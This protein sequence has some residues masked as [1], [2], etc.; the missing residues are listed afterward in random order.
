M[1]RFLSFPFGFDNLCGY[2]F[3]LS[4]LS[5]LSKVGFLDGFLSSSGSLF[6]IGLMQF[7]IVGVVSSH[8][9]FS[10]RDFNF[11]FLDNEGRTFSFVFTFGLSLLISLTNLCLE[12]FIL[13]VCKNSMHPVAPQLHEEFLFLHLGGFGWL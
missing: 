4:G 11:S 1:R 8:I 9:A 3:I 5:A 10:L 7:I 12:Y 2:H 13:M 6:I